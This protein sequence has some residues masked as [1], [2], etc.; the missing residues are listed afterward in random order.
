MALTTGLSVQTTFGGRHLEAWHVK[1]D[2]S[3]TTFTPG[4][5]CV[6]HAWLQS[7]SGVT[8][9]LFASISSGVITMT[10]H[11]GTALENGKWYWLF[12]MGSA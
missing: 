12:F 5:A 8:V 4:V 3:T 11:S 6:D 9:G 1:G 2:G 10:Q 7:I